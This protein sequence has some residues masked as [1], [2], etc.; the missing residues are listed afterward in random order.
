MFG[1]GFKPGSKLTDTGVV[2]EG[3]EGR[4]EQGRSIHA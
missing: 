3:G 1:A 4:H 2:S